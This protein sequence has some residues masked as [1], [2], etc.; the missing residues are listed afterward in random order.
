[1]TKPSPKPKPAPSKPVAPPPKLSTWT[2]MLY[3]AWYAS[4]K[5]RAKS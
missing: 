4:R 5:P 2:P 3:S 1:M